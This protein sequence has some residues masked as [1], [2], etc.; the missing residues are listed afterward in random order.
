NQVLYNLADRGIEFDLLPWSAKAGLPVMAYS[1]IEQGRLTMH[2]VLTTIAG[3]HSGATPV[4]VALAF[5]LRQPHVC[6]I[7]QAGTPAH[8]AENR[9]AL[10]LV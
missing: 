8:V 10:D 2:P 5:V 3:R 6:A 4:Q 9:A 7:P 1:P